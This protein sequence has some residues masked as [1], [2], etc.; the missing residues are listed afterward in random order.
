[1][2]RL[3]FPQ[4]HS[5]DC[6]RIILVDSTR[7]G[8]RFPD[9]LSKTVPLWC[10][11]INTAMKTQYNLTHWDSSLY[12]TPKAVS[13]S[14]H[15]QIEARIAEFAVNLNASQVDLCPNVLVLRMYH[16]RH[17]VLVYREYPN[18]FDLCGS[19]LIPSSQ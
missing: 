16:L 14:E 4:C 15:S 18:Q 9:A 7:R 1:M 3:S 12:T 5:K 13:R 8:K 2:S 19:L 11:V 6:P 10:A 17:Q